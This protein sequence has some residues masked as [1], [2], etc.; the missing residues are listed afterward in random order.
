MD[1][2][3]AG[4]LLAVRREVERVC[5][6][7][8]SPTPQSL[9]ES[10]AILQSAIDQMKDLQPAAKG[11]ALSDSGALHE[12]GQVQTVLRRAGMLL[13]LAHDYHLRWQR[14]LGGMSSGYTAGGSPAAAPNQGRIWFQG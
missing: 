2:P 10:T 6:M 8:E 9:D 5:K 1:G 11:A 13:R 7:L 14:I 12:A 3:L 4:R